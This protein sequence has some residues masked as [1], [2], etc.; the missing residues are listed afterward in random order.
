MPKVLPMSLVRV[1]P[2]SLVHV[3]PMSLVYTPNPGTGDFT[4]S[5]GQKPGEIHRSV[6]ASCRILHHARSAHRDRQGVQ[7]DGGVGVPARR[8]HRH[9]GLAAA[10]RPPGAR[11]RARH[12][13][14][15]TRAKLTP[16]P[17]YTLYRFNP[18]NPPIT[19]SSNHPILQSP[20]LNA[21]LTFA[22]RNP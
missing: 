1:L 9:D 13:A 14:R 22:L 10:A 11:S 2:M 4:I 5:G 17:L 19:Q 7:G 20:N 16:H 6:V 3:L 15:A 18:P 12:L 21:P 8:L